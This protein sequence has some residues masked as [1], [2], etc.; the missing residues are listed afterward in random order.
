MSVSKLHRELELNEI[1]NKKNKWLFCDIE[2]S[3]YLVKRDN[4][5]LIS[6]GS[7]WLTSFTAYPSY[8]YDL[9]KLVYF[10]VKQLFSKKASFKINSE[11]IIFSTGS[12][13][14]LKNYNKFFLDSNIELIQIEAFK[15][16]QFIHFNIVKIK[17]VFSFFLENLREA[18]S[19]LR[20]KLPPDLRKKIFKCSLPNLANYSY[21]CAFLS[22]IK[23]KNPNVKIFHSGAYLV[24]TAATRVGIETVYLHH[25]LTGKVG[26][27]SFPFYNQIYV[28]SAEEQSYLEDISPNSNIC[29]YPTKELS[30]LEKRVVVFLRLY[31]RDMS[32]EDLSELLTFFLKKDYK[33][34]LKKPPAYTGSLTEILESKYNLEIIDLEKDA[35]E[36]ILNLRPTFAVG[37]MSTA[38][39]ESLLHG[40][41]P[42]SLSGEEITWTDRHAFTIYPIKKRS[43]SW[44]EEKERIF[45]LLEDF[46]LYTKTLSELR[47]R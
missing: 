8:I 42:I 16:S 25:G 46:N 17:S 19:V 41:V 40:V 44:K 36:I 22:A 43:F 33:I 18:S 7:N 3:R 38:L 39:C 34:F 9:L 31:D 12:G 2:I 4:F 20:L 14:D 24:S 35:S 11:H 28:Y 27:A 1:V 5:L 47:T 15:I 29:L 45:E 32:E 13:Y 6:S 10:L 37:W 26:R 23:E 21:Y 30:Q